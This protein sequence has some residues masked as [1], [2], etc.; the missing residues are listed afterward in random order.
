MQNLYPTESQWLQDEIWMPLITPYYDY[1]GLYSVSN[2]GRVWAVRKKCIMK[3]YTTWNGRLEIG[4]SNSDF[5]KRERIHRLVAYVFIPNPNNLPQINHKDGNTK[6]NNINNLEWVTHSENMLHAYEHGLISKKVGT[7]SV[8][9]KYPEETI[10]SVINDLKNTEL[11]VPELSKKYKI[12]K[13]L[14]HSIQYGNSWSHLSGFHKDMKWQ[15][16][17]SV[18]KRAKAIKDSGFNFNRTELVAIDKQTNEIFEFQSAK[19]CAKFL[20]VNKCMISKYL[21]H[22][23]Q[24]KKYNIMYK[25]DY[26]SNLK[27]DI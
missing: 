7:N 24:N 17:N 14:I 5:I 19:E 9:S 20:E 3:Q 8:L 26:I 27:L 21:K 1:T 2:L 10:K 23:V 22:E 11:S 4:L 6:N 13:G 18:E 12:S 15:R 16:K 25:Q